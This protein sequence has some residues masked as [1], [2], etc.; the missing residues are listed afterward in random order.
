MLEATLTQPEIQQDQKIWQL[1]TQE[2]LLPG[3]ANDAEAL[4]GQTRHAESKGL[5]L[6]QDRFSVDE[7][8]KSLRAVLSS[9][10]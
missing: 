1:I 3:H 8:A 10:T 9:K 7:N 4:F 6:P 2:D 5:L